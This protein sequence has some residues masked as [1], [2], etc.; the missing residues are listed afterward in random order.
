L[1]WVLTQ[2]AGKQ[3]PLEKTLTLKDGIASQQDAMLMQ[4]ATL[5]ELVLVLTQKALAH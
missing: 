2:K 3:W 4:K 1:D 5:L